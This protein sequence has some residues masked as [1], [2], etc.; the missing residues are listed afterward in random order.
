MVWSCGG[1]EA[2]EASS[3]P[4]PIPSL[5]LLF[6]VFS[7]F[8]SSFFSY[9]SFFFH[10]FVNVTFCNNPLACLLRVDFKSCLWLGWFCLTFY[11]WHGSSYP[12]CPCLLLPLCHCVTSSPPPPSPPLPPDTHPLVIDQKQQESASLTW[13]MHRSHLHLVLLPLLL[14][15]L[16]HHYSVSP[17]LGLGVELGSSDG[18]GSWQAWC[19]GGV[20]AL[21]LLLIANKVN[22]F[23]FFF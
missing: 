15:L 18:D 10:N 5:F 8:T 17:E 1:K 20:K 16:L 23:F 21:L 12:A 22:K 14:P 7:S 3:S 9:S 19:G 2:T 6:L 11:H 13:L 4:A